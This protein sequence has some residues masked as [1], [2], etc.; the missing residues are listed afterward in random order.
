MNWYYY[1]YV[2]YL[3]AYLDLDFLAAGDLDLLLLFL[4]LPA[5]GVLFGELL[6]D[7]AERP[8][9]RPRPPDLLRLDSLL[10]L[11]EGLVLPDLPREPDL[12]LF[13]RNKTMWTNCS[14]RGTRKQLK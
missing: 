2:Y 10:L 7:E 14:V 3:L 12:L 6:S 8:L 13:K 9:P 5:A 1:Y 11:R 4:F